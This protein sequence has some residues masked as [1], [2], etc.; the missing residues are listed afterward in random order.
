[1]AELYYNCLI[2]EASTYLLF[3]VTYGYQPST[4]ADQLLPLTGATEDAAIRLTLIA[5]IRDVVNPI[6][7]LFKERIAARST[8]SAHSSQPGDFV[9]LST[10]GLHVRSQKCKHL[11][12]Q[13]YVH[14]SLDPS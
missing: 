7:K 12:D 6:L 11:R 9:Y 5:D 8:R 3:E 14:T 2:N 10:K 13:N 1:M 4:P